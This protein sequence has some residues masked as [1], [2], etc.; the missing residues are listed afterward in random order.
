MLRTVMSA[1]VTMNVTSAPRVNR[2]PNAVTNAAC[3]TRSIASPASTAMNAAGVPSMSRVNSGA[4]S[5]NTIA[6]SPQTIPAV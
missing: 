3:S 1:T 5:P 4:S 6:S 2:P